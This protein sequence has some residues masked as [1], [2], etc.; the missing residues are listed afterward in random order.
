MKPTLN[1]SFLKKR[2]IDDQ[3]FSLTLMA[4][5]QRSGIYR[6]EVGESERA[7]FRGAL[8]S[9]L[10][11]LAKEYVI[12][13]P[14]EQ[15]HKNIKS[16][17]ASLSTSHGAYLSNNRFRIGLA[18]KSLNLYLKYLWCLG[19]LDNE[20]PECPIDRI[21]LDKIGCPHCKKINWTSI[22]TISEYSVAI[23]HASDA[24]QK[25]GLSLAEWEL[26][27]WSNATEGR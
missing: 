13:V 22:D 12:E 19:R 17:S 21:V 24:A 23:E 18:Q 20:P 14:R 16:L 5:T 8:K 15:H 10:E 27:V 9:A 6:E 2:F 4:T 3:V 25:N 26:K 11:S 1:L 7:K